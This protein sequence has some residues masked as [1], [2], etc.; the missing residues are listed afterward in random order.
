MFGSVLIANRGE[1][2]RRVIR[3]CRGLGIESI[4]VYSTADEDALFVKEADRS[5]CIGPARASESYLN[6]EAV[7]EAAI[8]SDAQAI[9]PGYGFL[10]EN[11]LFAQMVLQQ[12]LAWIGPPPRVIR[13]MGEK[14]AAKSAMS[15]AGLP[16]IPG[17]DGL[18]ESLED[19]RSL[20]SELG[21]PGLVK[22]SAG[23]IREH[24]HAEEP[25]G[26]GVKVG[27]TGIVGRKAGGV[28]PDLL[29]SWFDG[30]G[31]R[32]GVAMG[33]RRGGGHAWAR[34]L[35]REVQ[36]V[37][38]RGDWKSPRPVHMALMLLRFAWPEA[39]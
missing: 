28:S 19:A 13:M 34:S 5:V 7:L 18:I 27:V 22:A 35:Q 17:S 29:P 12:R 37:T 6:M 32:G 33:G 8:Q 38:G 15:A 4:A 36:K 16:M 39:A 25:L 11:A 24:V 3:A 1:I 2:A 30:G 31:E 21:Y 10:S 9:H 14:A 26:L 20:A 23:G